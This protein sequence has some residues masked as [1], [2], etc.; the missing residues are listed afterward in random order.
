MSELVDWDVNTLTSKLGPL[1]LEG[2]A[3]SRIATTETWSHGNFYF[4]EY[5]CVEASRLITHT[6]V[7]NVYSW[8][9]PAAW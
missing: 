3:S 2:E 7:N 6:C 5:C 4:G 8:G 9:I 1:N